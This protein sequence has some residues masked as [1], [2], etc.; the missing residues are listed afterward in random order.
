MLRPLFQRGLLYNDSQTT[1]ALPNL[2]ASG[3]GT[4]VRLYGAL[5]NAA[6]TRLR[7]D[8]QLRE[9][10]YALAADLDS[11]PVSAPITPPAHADTPAQ[12]AAPVPISSGMELLERVRN[13]LEDSAVFLQEQGNDQASQQLAAELAALQAALPN[14]AGSRLPFARTVV[15][16]PTT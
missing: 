3:H 8:D 11:A 16:A 1:T 15:G 10:C 6:V 14:L 4:V 5:R 9:R 12:P 7:E 13:A 2:A